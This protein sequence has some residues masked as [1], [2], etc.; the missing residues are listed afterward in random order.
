LAVVASV[1]C[2]R[3]ALA[4]PRVSGLSEDGKV[5]SEAAAVQHL[6]GTLIAVR[7]GAPLGYAVQ[8][9]DVGAAELLVAAGESGVSILTGDGSVPPGGGQVRW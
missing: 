3:H 2:L 8:H 7:H 6:L 1:A 5:Q 4:D 9:P